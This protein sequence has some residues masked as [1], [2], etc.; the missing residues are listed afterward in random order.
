M[1]PTIVGADEAH[2]TFRNELASVH[3]DGRR[4]WVYARQPAGRFYT[5]RTL[6]AIVL[7]AFLVGAPFVHAGGQ[8]LILLNVLERRFVLFG[9][10]FWPQ[11]FA[12]VVL[13][14]LTAI[15]TLAIST[16]AVG[17]IWCGWLCPQTVFLEMIFR[18][19]E[20]LIDGSAERQVRRDATPWTAATWTRAALKQ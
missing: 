8:P 11:D 2:E 3:R 20:Y 13:L 12:L 18:R 4:K 15:V 10:V 19:I 16:A 1:A 9:L 14:A 17:R 5:A 6:I 7:L